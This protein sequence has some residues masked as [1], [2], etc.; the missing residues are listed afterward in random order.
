[1]SLGSK[2]ALT[3]ENITTVFKFT[4][5]WPLIPRPM[6]NKMASSEAFTRMN[7]S[8]EEDNHNLIVEEVLEEVIERGNSKD[9]IGRLP[10]LR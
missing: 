9:Y 1:M 5:I 8:V 7:V 6:D 4:G 3:L 2:K 10:L